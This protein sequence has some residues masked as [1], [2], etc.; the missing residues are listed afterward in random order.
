MGN[1]TGSSAI[2]MA[3][4][5]DTASPM[6]SDTTLPSE[7][8]TTDFARVAATYA[9]TSGTNTYTLSNTFTSA[10]GSTVTLAK[11]GIFTASSAG[12]L[13]FETLLSSTAVMNTGDTALIVET[14]TI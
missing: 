10:T 1:S 3:V 4:T 14:V 8:V 2:Y 5:Q 12:T 9:H 11:I 6:S 13:V 7:I